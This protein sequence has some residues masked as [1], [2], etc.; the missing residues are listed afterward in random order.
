[1]ASVLGPLSTTFGNLKTKLGSPTKPQST[2]E[3]MLP[4][5]TDLYPSIAVSSEHFDVSLEDWAALLELD[6]DA[7]QNEANLQYEYAISK[8][9]QT[10]AYHK[11]AERSFTLG[12]E[13]KY[14]R[15]AAKDRAVV[16]TWQTDITLP[17]YAPSLDDKT[18]TWTI[19]YLSAPS[20]DCACCLT[21]HA[22]A[23]LVRL[24]CEHVWCAPCLSLLFK[25]ATEQ[26]GHYPP[27]CCDTITTAIAAP[28][29]ALP[30]RK[31]YEA[32]APEWENRD[33]TYCS[34]R[35]CRVWIPPT[36]VDRDQEVATCPKCGTRTC[37]ACK[38][39]AH[40][41]GCPRDEAGQALRTL[42]VRHGWRNCP[43][44]SRVVERRD[45]CDHMTHVSGPSLRSNWS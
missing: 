32:K 43:A 41:G 45:G 35:C 38:G 23:H 26:E 21:P 30:T 12:A 22:A 13:R 27:R 36:N 11:L 37:I 4:Q 7:I 15:E 17:R 1:M 10:P 16:R 42:I 18:A 40:E 19:R 3:D 28:A 34:H 29:L 25:A 9:R 5:Y 14:L 33:R 24:P 8:D 31:A 39:R 6:F 2:T 44:C 20:A